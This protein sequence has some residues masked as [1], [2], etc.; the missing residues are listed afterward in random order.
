MLSDIEDI[1]NDCGSNKNNFHIAGG[2]ADVTNTWPW[3]ASLGIRLN[4]AQMQS[5]KRNLIL[6]E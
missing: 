5:F 1:W 3:M 4:N 6:K 2:V